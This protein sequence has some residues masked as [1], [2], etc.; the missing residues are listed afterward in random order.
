MED[1]SSTDDEGV[2]ERHGDESSYVDY[3]PVRS[4]RGRRTSKK[5]ER[6]ATERRINKVGKKLEKDSN[7]KTKK[8][9]KYLW[10]GEKAQRKHL[11]HLM[12]CTCKRCSIARRPPPKKLFTFKLFS[13]D[14][15]GLKF[16]PADAGL[17]GSDL[18]SLKRYR[19]RT[20]HH[21]HGNDDLSVLFD[22]DMC[23]NRMQHLWPLWGTLHRDLRSLYSYDSSM[24][25]SGSSST[26]SSSDSSSSSSS[27]YTS[28]E[29][30]DTDSDDVKDVDGVL[31]RRRHKGRTG[32]RPPP[33]PTAVQVPRSNSSHSN[34]TMTGKAP[35]TSSTEW[36]NLSPSVNPSGGTVRAIPPVTT[37]RSPYQKQPR[38][39]RKKVRFLSQ[40]LPSPPI[41]KSPKDTRKK[42][43]GSLQ[44]ILQDPKMAKPGWSV[45]AQPP[46]QSCI[47]PA[48]AAAADVTGTADPSGAGKQGAVAACR[49]PA[50]AS[51]EGY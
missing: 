13:C 8:I 12:Q 15:G 30:S 24:G 10:K 27:S 50:A 19:R 33:A 28:E 29:S 9:L 42:P 32:P 31:V 16:G 43:A 3:I 48:A 25:S 47:L 35:K 1:S 40:D 46:P 17:S 14:K 44:G 22:K 2:T 51:V 26:S 49:K 34:Q 41:K 38:K 6:R 21:Q 37:S 39:A 23:T 20:R 11:D 5:H 7:K 18:R 36:P 45:A 4:G